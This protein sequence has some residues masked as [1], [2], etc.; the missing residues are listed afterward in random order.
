MAVYG[1]IRAEYH[2]SVAGS[3]GDESDFGS[4][5]QAGRSGYNPKSNKGNVEGSG[6]WRT[7]RYGVF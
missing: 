4:G 7:Y 6:L 1:E 3:W 2:E 5:G